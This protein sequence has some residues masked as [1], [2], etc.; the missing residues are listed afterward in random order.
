MHSVCS[1]EW[2]VVK[3]DLYPLYCWL[4]LP[5]KQTCNSLKTGL[6]SY[7]F[8]VDSHALVGGNPNIVISR[9][10]YLDALTKSSQPTHFAVR[11][12]ELVF[13]DDVLEASTVTGG[14]RGTMQLDPVVI[15]AIQSMI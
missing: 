1:L 15:K 6:I 2:N 5:G 8:V 13:G 9:Q 7:C 14:K 12:A 4:S 10:K 11:L 3:V